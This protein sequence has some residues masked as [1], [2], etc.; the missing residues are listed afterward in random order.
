[1]GH[2]SFNDLQNEVNTYLADY[3]AGLKAR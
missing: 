1:M 2:I 3:Q